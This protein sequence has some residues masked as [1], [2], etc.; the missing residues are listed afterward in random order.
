DFHL[1]VNA[2]NIA[3]DA[4]ELKKY[5]GSGVEIT[6]YSDNMACIAVQGP[7][8]EGILEKIFGFRLRG[9]AYYS[10]KEEMFKEQKVWVSRSGY[11]GEDGFELFCLNELAPSVWDVLA[12]A[13]KKE[14]A[15]PA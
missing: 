11:T 1:V 8:S 3:R 10:F 12:D 14:G 6:D 13:G 7:E 5:A 15:L 9:M 4:A 2:S